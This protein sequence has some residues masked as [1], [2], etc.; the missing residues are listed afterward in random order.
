[1]KKA[2]SIIII[3][4]MVCG[5][6]F[7][8]EEKE[9][10]AT[11]ERK[12]AKEERK[13]FWEEPV[14]IGNLTLSGIIGTFFGL[15][16][17]VDLDSSKKKDTFE[18]VDGGIAATYPLADWLDLKA[19]HDLNYISYNKYTDYSTLDNYTKAG[20][21]V[22]P[23]N[24][25]SADVYYGFDYL[26]YPKDEEGTYQAHI[27]GISSRQNLYKTLYH[28]GGSE[29][30]YKE[31]TDRKRRDGSGQRIDSKQ[32][33]YRYTN[34][35]E[36]GARILEA[37][38]KA[39]F[40][41]YKNDSN[42]PYYDYYDYD[43][44]KLIFSVSRKIIGNLYGLASFGRQWRYYD[45]R[46]I[47]VGSSEKEEDKTWLANASLYYSITPYLHL[48]GTYSY[49]DNTSNN[50]LSKYVNYLT[51]AGVYFTF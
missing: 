38:L 10:K 15:D 49:R 16:S 31:Y 29:F 12:I 37:L 7:A 43:S 9:I 11:E 19:S 21:Q 22:R 51:S 24:F 25:I 48:V 36:L 14:K 6:A 44:Y 33:D 32:H 3:A 47:Q 17:N 46:V 34:Y 41:Y 40:E 4:F 27:I 35:Q 2:I 42:D 28:D 13:K 50:P 45:E 30:M 23:F 18:E 5:L 39:K 8:Q 1:M 20:F 26:W